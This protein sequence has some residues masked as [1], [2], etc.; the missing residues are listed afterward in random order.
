MSHGK[1]NSYPIFKDTDMQ[2][3]I[4]FK[5]VENNKLSLPYSHVQISIHVFETS[6][7]RLE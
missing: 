7:I 6:L 5:F 1:T 2:P 4:S 3:P